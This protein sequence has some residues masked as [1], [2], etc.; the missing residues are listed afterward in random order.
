MSSKRTAYWRTRSHIKIRTHTHTEIGNVRE[1]L[2]AAKIANF[3][4]FVS[5]FSFFFVVWRYI[6]VTFYEKYRING[7][8]GDKR[9]EFID[10]EEKKLKQM[11]E[12]LSC[13]GS[14]TTYGRCCSL[15][16]HIL[17]G[18]FKTAIFFTT[19]TYSTHFASQQSP[20]CLDCCCFSHL[21]R[22]LFK[23]IFWIHLMENLFGLLGMLPPMWASWLVCF[24]E[25]P[26]TDLIAWQL[27]IKM[28]LKT[29]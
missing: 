13:S 8:K 25:Q 15:N 23:Q 21:L 10:D 12:F 14:N 6:L 26:N 20:I 9:A 29:L 7:W 4:R 16:E 19:R 1:L 17:N 28:N 18:R 24:A 3:F 22:W 11:P 2:W 27:S 5:F